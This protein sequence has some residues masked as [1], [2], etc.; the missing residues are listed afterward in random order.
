[1][2]ENEL[3]IDLITS[4]CLKNRI[5]NEYKELSKI[6][7]N[8]KILWDAELNNVIVEIYKL[9]KN[10]KID[11][12]TFTVNRTYPFHSPKFYYNNEPY[13]HYLRIPSQ[14]FSQHLT[15]FTKK[16]CL[17]CSSLACKYNWSPAVKLRMFI[18]EL[19]KIRQYKRNIVYKILADQV[20]DKYLIDDVDLDSYLFSSKQLLEKVVQINLLKRLNQKK[21]EDL[22]QPFPKVEKVELFGRPIN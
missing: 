20:K 17:C 1:M 21:V 19:D 3:Q 2:Y 18:A 4:K 5:K 10:D 6:Y 15:K 12:F 22:A 11:T 14:R 9:Y 8:V 16:V 13:S 7:N